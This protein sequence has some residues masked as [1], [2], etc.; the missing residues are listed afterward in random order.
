MKL[1]KTPPN[2]MLWILNNKEEN[3]AV[4]PHFRERGNMTSC[5]ETDGIQNQRLFLNLSYDFLYLS[6]LYIDMVA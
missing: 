6:Y 5:K 4:S 2:R 1:G 3:K